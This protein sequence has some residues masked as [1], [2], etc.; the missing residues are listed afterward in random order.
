[1]KNCVISYID[2]CIKKFPEKVAI[3]HNDIKITYRELSD[4]SDSIAKKI[5]DLGLTNSCVGICL[6]RVPEIIS[7]I[8]GIW[9]SGNAYIP[10]DPNYPSQRLQYIVSD[11]KIN[12]IFANDTTNEIADSLG[13]SNVVDVN[14]CNDNADYEIKNISANQTAYAIYTSGSTGNPKGVLISHGAFFNFIGS[15]QKRPG[16]CSEDRMLFNTTISFDISTL[17]MFLPLSVGATVVMSTNDSHIDGEMLATLVND[18][19]IT[20]IQGTPSMYT[21]L[22]EAGWKGNDSIKILSGGEAITKELASELIGKC[23]SLWNMYGPTETTVWSMVDEITD[24]NRITLGEPIDNTTIFILDEN[25]NPVNK[26]DAG[27]LLIGGLGL[28]KGYLGKEDLTKE[29]FISGIDPNG[30]AYKTGDIV[31]LC[32]DGKI[33]YQ[34]RKDFQIKLRGHR[35][36]LG[37]IESVINTVPNIRQTVV[38]MVQKSDSDKKLVAYYVLKDTSQ[39]VD[40]ATIKKEI[41]DNLPTYMMP[42]NYICLDSFPL[43]DNGKINRK[44]LQEMMVCVETDSEQSEDFENE[45]ELKIAEIWREVL[46]IDNVGRHDNF[47]DLGGHSLLANRLVLKIN[48]EFGIKLSLYE[49]LTE[50]MTVAETA[51]LLEAKL[52]SD[53]DEDELL[54]LLDGIEDIDDLSEE[55]LQSML[56][57]LE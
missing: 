20:M 5:N 35:I 7:T 11:S 47:L 50:G 22:L 6:D 38:V 14:A 21:M 49:L 30:L 55:E 56:E 10:L 9:K 40:V 29:R 25:M 34:G 54:E 15:M 13:V 53:F 46:E 23:K 19:K 44:E 51:Q 28:S 32:E 27:E 57:E 26:G 39:K 2:S 45:I 16:I 3:E 42:N 37:E 36:E 8:L 24:G 17:E 52:L 1:M 41:I 33:E 18:K 48:N 43:T 4:K 12:I 31:K